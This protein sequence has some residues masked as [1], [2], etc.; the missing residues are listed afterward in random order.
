MLSLFH[1]SVA[2]WPIFW[3]WNNVSRNSSDSVIKYPQSFVETAY[4]LQP[5]VF[6]TQGYYFLRPR[7]TCRVKSDTLKMG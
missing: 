3:V 1:A 6:L 2:S 7:T 4:L 5:A